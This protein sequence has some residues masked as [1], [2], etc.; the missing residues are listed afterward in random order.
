MKNKVIVALF[1]IASL[2]FSLT[3]VEAWAFEGKKKGRCCQELEKKFDYKTRIIFKNR[4][5]LELSDKQVD[6]IKALKLKI[7]KDLIRKNAE[8]EII[9]L[10][11][12][13]LMSKEKVDLNAANKLIDEKYTFKK[14]KMKSLVA[15][16]VAIKEILT[17]EQKSKL[18]SIW[19]KCKQEKMSGTRM[20]GKK[21][22]S[23]MDGKDK[24]KK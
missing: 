5:E 2:I 16:C 3:A 9:A 1:L 13:A 12:K 15:A 22:C 6:K 23:I 8:I 14:G 21:E 19:K 10:D 18:K 11:L 7:E 4:D 20:K 24:H 17:N